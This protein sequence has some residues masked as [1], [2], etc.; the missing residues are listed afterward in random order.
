MQNRSSSKLQIYYK[1]YSLPDYFPIIALLGSQWKATFRRLE[2][3][4][5]H[6]C[7]E[8]GF[9][10]SGSGNIC[11]ENSTYHYCSGDYSIIYPMI[12]HITL[13]SNQNGSNWEYIYVDPD[14]LFSKSSALSDELKHFSFVEQRFSPIIS[15][16]INSTLVF[17]LNELFTEFRQKQALYTDTVQD[18]LLAALSEADSMNLL[19]GRGIE[20]N[21]RL[22]TIYSAMSYI[23]MNF[24]HNI[25]M[26]ALADVC[27]ISLSHL[28]RIFTATTGL[29]PQKYLE[30]YRIRVSCRMLSEHSLP[31]HEIALKCGFSSLSSFNRQFQICMAMS[32]ST[33]QKLTRSGTNKHDVHSFAEPDPMHIFKF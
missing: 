29:S 26:S 11:F 16:N 6:N 1:P 20:Y 8:I 32:P 4:H 5:F 15:K 33:W 30:H 7:I 9:C 28:R 3:L 23:H 14:L 2:I 21:S 25:E 19:F 13:T 17:M 31:I 18:L 27:F 12:P 24:D 22:K 10:I